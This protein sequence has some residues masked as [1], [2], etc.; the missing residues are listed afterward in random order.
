MAS[1]AGDHSPIDVFQ[2]ISR[3]CV[4]S[5][6]R[7]VKVQLARPRIHC[8]IFEHRPKPDGAPD[9]GLVLRRKANAFRIT[10]AFKVEDALAAP[11]MLVVADQPPARVGG[12]G[13][14]AGAGK[15]EKERH[16]STFAKIGGAM[17]GKYGL[18]RQQV[19][20]DGKRGLLQL[21]GITGAHDENGPFAEV[22][23]DAG[24]RV[25]SV[26]RR[27]RMKVGRKPNRKLRVK[28]GSGRLA[29]NKQLPR[30]QTMP[31]GLRNHTN[32][33]RIRRVSANITILYVKALASQG[34]PDAGI[35]TVEDRFRH[36]LIDRSP[37]NGFF[38]RLVSHDEL[39]LWRAACKLAGINYQRAVFRECAFTPLDGMLDQKWRRK[40]P[41]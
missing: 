30:K 29:A 3:A 16:V 26:P 27:I 38:R 14:L 32:R 35:Q 40:I 7:S 41:K 31:R 11:T 6:L 21:S 19:I 22:D 13:G 1:H 2:R 28:S 33:Q 5:N 4:L 18:R 10:A 12:E 24:F 9:L 25:R 34:R 20:H 36:G 23:R 15:P 39:I 37:V 17:H 8:Y